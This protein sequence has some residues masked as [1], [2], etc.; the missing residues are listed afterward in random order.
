MNPV[1]FGKFLASLRNEKK[2][3][4][5]ELAEKLFID[6]RKISRWECGM[7]I[8]DFD[9]LIKLSEILDV[10]LYELSICKRLEKEKL[11][12]KAINK[13]KGIKDLRKYKFKQ[14]IKIIIAIVIGIVF[15]FSFIYTLKFYGTVNIYTIESQDEK[16]A[17]E[18]TF[19]ET[20]TYTI[21]NI[22]TINSRN[23]SKFSISDIKYCNL[24]IF[25]SDEYKIID[26]T[27][28]NTMVE[29]IQY[30]NLQKENYNHNI[31][32]KEINTNQ[33]FLKIVCN[34]NTKQEKRYSIKLHFAKI[35]DNKLF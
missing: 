19:V 18:G 16:Y 34:E 1:E 12:R 8:P 20:N 24:G 13:F 23:Q 11:T 7:S 2:L 26:F 29:N 5:E 25:N 21:I 9:M 30:I 31:I 10:S 6:K 22:N 3:T 28:L 33:L 15:L 32:N 4:Q 35:Y 27:K 17:L 14:I